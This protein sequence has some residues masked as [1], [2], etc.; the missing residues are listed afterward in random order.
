MPTMRSRG[1]SDPGIRTRCSGNRTHRD[2][3]GLERSKFTVRHS[4]PF[5]SGG[6][7]RTGARRRRRWLSWEK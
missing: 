4:D 2:G 5:L 6:H 3:T 1:T 7:G